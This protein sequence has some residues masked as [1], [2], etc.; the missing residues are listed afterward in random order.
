MGL[1][2]GEELT[3]RDL[4][5][6]LLLVSGNDAA[7]ALA[8]YVGGSVDDFVADMNDRAASL[9]MVNT[10]FANPHGLDADLHYSSA[11][12][13]LLLTR[14]AL[15]WA[16]FRE[17]VAKA[18]STVAGH[19]LVN[20]NQ[21]LGTYEGS[22]GVKTGTTDLAGECLVALVSRNGTRLVLVVLGSD[23]RYS[24][25]RALLDFAFTTYM[26]GVVGLPGGRLSQYTDAN[27]RVWVLEDTGAQHLL[28]PRWKWP[29]VQPYRELR[30]PPELPTEAPAGTV[31]F[32][33]GQEILAESPLYLREGW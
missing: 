10:R 25:A 3:V 15:N 22:E 7:M 13:L 8:D 11:A 33:I 2:Q 21:L 24:D 28:L 23:D 1:V 4:L 5:H 9:G 31:R 19:Y 17:I 18:E 32:E 29:L 30:L 27:G 20:T 12:D 16:E 6:G 14:E 26:A